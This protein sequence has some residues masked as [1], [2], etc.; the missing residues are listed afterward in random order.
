MSAEPKLQE[1]PMKTLSLL[2]TLSILALSILALSLAALSPAL[3]QSRQAAESEVI[4]EGD[5]GGA[6]SMSIDGARYTCYPDDD[7]AER[8]VTSCYC[9][10]GIYLGVHCAGFP[11]AD[12]CCAVKCEELRGLIDGTH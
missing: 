11:S 5:D 3:A 2:S 12:V 8:P 7:V 1:T 6:I 4:A 10:D 9:G